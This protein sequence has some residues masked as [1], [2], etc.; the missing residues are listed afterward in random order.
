MAETSKISPWPEPRA[1]KS[2]NTFDYPFAHKRM[3]FDSDGL[4]SAIFFN[5]AGHPRRP[6]PEQLQNW[7]RNP[8]A[9]DCAVVKNLFEGL[10]GNLLNEVLWN[11][12]ASIYEMARLFHTCNVDY[13]KA[14]VWVDQ[15]SLDS[16]KPKGV[17]S[18][19]E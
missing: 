9:A 14:I 2:L 18:Y 1:P 15:F 8:V 6:E 16:S 12:G 3:K 4:R 17:P 7:L 11:S 13:W 10:P 5:L 19:Y